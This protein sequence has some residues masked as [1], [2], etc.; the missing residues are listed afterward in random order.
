MKIAGTHFNPEEC[1]GAILL[2]IFALMAMGTLFVF[3]ASVYY[4]IAGVED[5][6]RHFRKHLFF[7]F[8]SALIM[9]VLSYFNYRFFL[10]DAI[11]FLLGFIT[12]ALLVLVLIPGVGAQINGAKRWI[13]FAGLSFQPSELA[14]L[15]GILFCARFLTQ[16]SD[17]LKDW[18]QGFLP[19]V[20]VIGFL[21]GLI[22]LEKDLGTPVLLVSVM[23]IMLLAGGARADHIALVT[24]VG[25]PLVIF[26]IRWD[27]YRMKRI[28]AFINPWQDARGTGYQLIQSW[29]GIHEGGISGV[30]LGQGMQKQGFLP[31]HMNDFIFAMVGEEMG[32]IGVSMLIA[33]FAVF[34]YAGW[35][36]IVNAPDQPGALIAT[37]VVATIGLQMLIHML[38]NVG[39]MPTKGISLPFVSLGGSSMLVTAAGI[40]LLLNVAAQASPVVEGVQVEGGQIA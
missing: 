15:T 36:I 1:R 12:L 17:R 22:V 21:A 24:A 28:L 39:L 3:S 34:L 33:L 25:I 26:L 18:K 16:Y 29:I 38:V 6:F 11:L 9:C 14:K 20:A 35:K 13:R 37:G 2:S 32:A 19:V 4:P 40:G 5:P 27:A 7:V 23:F 30:G 10:K 8:G 31:A